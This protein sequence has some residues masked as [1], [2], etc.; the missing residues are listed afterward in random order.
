LTTTLSAINLF[1]ILVMWCFAVASSALLA[2]REQAAADLVEDAKALLLRGE[3]DRLHSLL[4]SQGSPFARA[5][6]A[7][8]DRSRLTP[9][10][11]QG[12]GL[13]AVLAREVRR[14][15][16]AYM[17][18]CLIGVL[19]LLASL[20]YPSFSPLIYLMAERVVSVKLGSSALDAVMASIPLV[21]AT[22]L[23]MRAAIG[24]H[25][26]RDAAITRM[27]AWIE[28]VSALVRR[29]TTPPAP[30][31]PPQVVS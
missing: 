30:P 2:R 31:A 9:Q 3:P 11:V 1:A 4:T 29:G 18:V 8:I 25:R 10:E 24:I 23:T 21:L 26:L 15:D 16:T 27:V 20:V 17:F 28:E 7:V 14:D 13:R 5:L 22:I 12:R 6:Q 19:L